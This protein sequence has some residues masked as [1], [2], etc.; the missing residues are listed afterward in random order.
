MFLITKLKNK[1][2]KEFLATNFLLNTVLYRGNKIKNGQG[3]Y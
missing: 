1:A 3:C 2:L